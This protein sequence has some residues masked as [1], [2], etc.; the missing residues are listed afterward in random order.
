MNDR[1]DELRTLAERAGFNLTEQEL[2]DVAGSVESGRARLAA[3]RAEIIE[4]EEPAN[5]FRD[6]SGARKS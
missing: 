1:I 2:K 4:T 6:P 5:I 3:L